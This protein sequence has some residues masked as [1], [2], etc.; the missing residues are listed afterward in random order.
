MYVGQNALWEGISD[1]TSVRSTK[2][3]EGSRGSLKGTIALAIDVLFLLISF[4][5]GG[6]FLTKILNFDKSFSLSPGPQNSLVPPCKISLG[7]HVCMFCRSLFVLLY[8]FFWPLCCLFFFFDIRFLITPLVSSNS[9]LPYIFEFHYTCTSIFCYYFY[10]SVKV[11]NI[12]CI[13]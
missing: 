13:I 6:I 5:G 11:Y 7:G 3:R 10:S 12:E 4:F 9:S 2:S 8:F 1:S